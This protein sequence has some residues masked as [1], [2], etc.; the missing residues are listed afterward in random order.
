MV[1]PATCLTKDGKARTAI[2]RTNNDVLMVRGRPALCAGEDTSTNEGTLI[3][4]WIWKT[5]TVT[6]TRSHPEH[7]GSLGYNRCLQTSMEDPR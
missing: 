1:A 7:P 2:V 6:L 4:L 5:L 3:C